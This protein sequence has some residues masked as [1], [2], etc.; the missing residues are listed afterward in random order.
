MR[1]IVTLA[2]LI[3]I[4]LLPVLAAA[5]ESTCYGT[6]ANGRLENGVALPNKGTN[7][8]SYTALGG[9]LGRTYVHSRVR[10]V[11]V[12]SFKALEISRPETVY[13]Y[14]ETGKRYGGSFKPH[15]THQNGL[16]VDFMVPV[17]DSKDRSTPLP[18]NIFNKYGYSIEFDAKGQ[19]GSYR[20]DFEAMASHLLALKQEMDRAGIG[21]WRVIFDP[22]LQPY[23]FKTKSG[24]LLKQNNISFSKKRS[25]VR[26]D[27]H[28]HV[29]FI[30]ACEEM[31]SG[32][33]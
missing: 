27:E 29:D 12:N 7:F 21:M 32:V 2:A 9:I 18:T 14:G 19:H 13:V 20:I 33:K 1:P 24:S 4:F 22:Q 17:L 5:V 3:S 8:R 25:W 16:S 31:E 28:Y 30:V 23:L 15:R 10:D 11:I 6:T 26:H